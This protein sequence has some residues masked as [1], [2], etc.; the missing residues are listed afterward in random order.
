MR[1][2]KRG[3]AAAEGGAGGDGGGQ[4]RGLAAMRWERTCDQGALGLRR[5]GRRWRLAAWRSP[6]GATATAAAAVRSGG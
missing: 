3:A 5:R 1:A 2:V 6:A 4:E